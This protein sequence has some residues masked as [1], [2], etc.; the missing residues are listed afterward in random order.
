MR[1]ASLLSLGLLGVL[2]SQAFAYQDL[3]I[4]TPH[5]QPFVTLRIFDI[6]ES[7]QTGDWAGMVGE[8]QLSETEL[9]LITQGVSYWASLLE[10][11]LKNTSAPIIEVIPGLAN[12]GNA[13]STSMSMTN[14]HTWLSA[15]LLENDFSASNNGITAAILINRP[16]NKDAQWYEGSLHS[17]SQNGESPALSATLVHELMHSLGMGANNM[18]NTSLTEEKPG[19]YPVMTTAF[20]E[21]LSRWNYG[22]RDVD[23]D[24]PRPGMVISWEN[25]GSHNEFNMPLEMDQGSSWGGIYFTGDHVNEVLQGALIAFPDDRHDLRVPGLPVRGW[26]FT[27][28]DA[29][30]FNLAWIAELSH[31]E[32][33]NSLMSHQYWRNWNVLMEAELAVMQDLGF[34]LDRRNWFG[35]SVYQSGEDEN[36]RYHF[37]N[38]N[39][40][41][42]RNAAGT[43]WLVGKA[44]ENPWGIG[45]HIYG[46]YTD[47][48]QA[49]DILTNGRY[50]VGVRVEGVGNILR[51]APDTVIEANGNEGYGLLVSYGKNHQIAHFGTVTALGE[52]GIAARFDFGSNLLGDDIE[53]RGS[54]ICTSEI[55]PDYVFL[56][57]DLNGPLIK[58]FDVAGTL[59]GKKAA[60]FI[61]DNALVETINVFNGAYLSGDIIS[62][63]NPEDQR[64]QLPEGSNQSDFVTKLNFGVKYAENIEDTTTYVADPQFALRYDGHIAS[65][66]DQ[67]S[68]EWTRAAIRMNV[69][70]GKLSFNGEA[71]LIDVQVQKGAVLGGNATFTVD[72]F[73]NNGTLSPGNSIG[74]VTIQGDYIEGHDGRLELEFDASGQTDEIQIEGTAKGL[75]DVPLES[76]NTVFAPV[77]DYYSQPITVDFSSAVTLIEKDSAGHS[78]ISHGQLKP[79]AETSGTVDLDVDSPTLTMTAEFDESN[80]LSVNVSRAPNAYSRYA[81]NDLT[82]D[83]AIAFDRHASDAFGSMQNLVAA[84]DFS[85]Q[86]GSDLPVAYEALGPGIF[87]AAG[88]ASTHLL[89]HVSNVLLLTSVRDTDQGQGTGV[90]VIPLGGY[91]H[92]KNL[93]MRSTYGGVLLGANTAE[94]LA[95]GEVVFGAHAALTKRKDV[96]SENSE[97]RLDADTFM[98]GAHARYTPNSSPNTQLFGLTQFAV[99]NAD[100][101]RGVTF[102]SW[103]DMASSDWTGWGGNVVAG[104]QQLFSVSSNVTIGPVAWVDYAFSHRPSVTESSANG[105]ALY[106][107][108]ETYQSLQSVVGLQGSWRLQDNANESKLN[109]TITVAWH[110]EFIDE[111]GQTRASFKDWRDTPFAANDS[112]RASDTGSIS[113][114]L[115]SQLSES[116][117]ASLTAGTHFGSGSTGGWGAASIQWVF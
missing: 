63:W 3:F 7:G 47:V 51:I 39:P 4:D 24:A 65:G 91:T 35:Y 96:F 21:V 74:T 5:G 26:E 60:I 32:L 1:K 84:L 89:H 8:R 14:G 73:F 37:V 101:D 64:L 46:S 20:D 55:Y 40:F 52:E 12:D 106:V 36:N 102:N 68:G 54:Y 56:T 66:F 11:G 113:L 116:L 104:V 15:A 59:I 112:N 86:D 23:G 50:G 17:F 100:L 75:N 13:A 82:R 88:A 78:T 79:I 92:E 18:Q 29:S 2:T 114:S 97:S 72:Q 107:E 41:Y 90:F 33:Q 110:H 115:D 44:N 109:M 43:D 28:L 69:A 38:T 25:T 31:I 76:F 53:L 49:A 99:E 94:T 111:E 58:T 87:S 95:S 45:L 93:N 34:E 19:G 105:A 108:S 98:V 62:K 61:A 103:H 22:L 27:P 70:G 77:A 10:G 67:D 16:M 48:T 85:A 9:S 30:G 71:N 81:L 80:S 83:L 57:D 42:A 117:N 6:G